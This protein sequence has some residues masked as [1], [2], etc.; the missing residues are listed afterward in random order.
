MKDYFQFFGTRMTP[1]AN[2]VN[3]K[4]TLLTAATDR[5]TP[6]FSLLLYMLEV[7]DCRLLEDLRLGFVGDAA[8]KKS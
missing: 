7:V 5:W 1:Q 6:S 8:S 3:S 2:T 4:T